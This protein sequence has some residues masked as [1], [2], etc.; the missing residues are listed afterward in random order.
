MA[1]TVL[2]IWVWLLP[3]LLTVWLARGAAPRWL[4]SAVLVQWMAFGLWFADEP[5]SLVRR[6]GAIEVGKDGR[7]RPT[8]RVVT[9]NCAASSRAAGEVA[10]LQPDIV[11]LQES[12]S[13]LDVEALART[14]FGDSGSSVAGPDTSIVARG[15]VQ[16]LTPRG[17]T[18][19]CFV[20]A[21]VRL[22]EGTSLEVISL[23]L[24]PALVRVDLWS[25]GCWRAQSENRRA[26]RVELAT[27]AGAFAALQPSA[28]L[29]VGGDFNAP[30]GDGVY[31]LL[32]P[33]LADSFATAGRGWGNTIVNGAPFH[34][35][36]QVWIGGP[37]R[38][39]GTRAIA[40]RHSD[41]RMVVCD[42]V[43]DDGGA[44]GK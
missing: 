27:V 4:L 40:T 22:P 16:D 26:R 19:P 36:D 1:V 44:P 28:A 18:F 21:R 20:Q 5:L 2:P 11:L 25:P 6:G 15:E 38:A 37:L 14:L 32:K 7:A 30:A 33:R 23:R 13:S 9:L 42:L 41:H 3:G 35:I 29:I 39:N 10:A 8:V 17:G 43:V 12:P 24:R 34:R 31:D